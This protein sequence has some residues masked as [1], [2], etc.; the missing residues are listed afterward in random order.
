MDDQ[1]TRSASESIYEALAGKGVDVL[2]DDRDE[3]AGVKFNDADLVGIPFRIT[4]G[5]RGVAK[6]IAE[7]KR[8]RGGETIE[9]EIAR[10][11]EHVAA[12][13]AAERK[14]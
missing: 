2:I 14:V 9:V 11:A 13:I 7:V 1:A 12:A 10:V 8:R 4:L 5:P 6:G 3:R